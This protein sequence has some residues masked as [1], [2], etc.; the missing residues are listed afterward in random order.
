MGER[1]VGV[2]LGALAKFFPQHQIEEILRATKREGKRRRK[3]PAA[4]VMYYLVALGLHA[5]EGC[6]SVLRRVLLRKGAHAEDA[7]DE[8]SS[9]SAIS[10]AR[11]RLGSK[12]IRELYAKVVQPIATRMTKG[13]WYRKWRLVSLD[14]CTLDVADTSRNERAFGRATVTRG[15]APFPQLRWVTLLENG[16]HV[17]FGAEMGGYRVGETTLAKKVVTRLP[18]DALCLADR[19][20]F[21]YPLWNAVLAT[22]AALLWRVRTDL[23]LPKLRLL[24][25]GSYLSKIYPSSKARA[26]DR[27]GVLV[28][29]IEYRLEPG[30]TEM[31]RLLCSIVEPKKAPGV[32]LANLYAKRWTIET[33]L[34]ELKTRLRGARVVLRSKIPELVRQDFYGL[35]LAHFGVRALMHEAALAEKI[36][37]TELSFVHALRTIAR[38][39]PLYVS[40]F[41][42]KQEALAITLV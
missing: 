21:S 27:N 39:L 9:D 38:Y 32:Q 1:P 33:A 15:K 8:M 14:G 28:R 20:F 7:F 23:I 16:T 17:L 13:A 11:V 24:S 5:S 30:G 31:Y 22:G 41:P 25:D 6:R 35:L 12:P 3:L 26:K 18:A 29:V 34:G 40:F 4:D 10:Q 2:S 36:D 19:N 37:P 42:S